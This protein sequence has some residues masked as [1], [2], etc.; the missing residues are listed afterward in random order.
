VSRH[1]GGRRGGFPGGMGGMGGGGGM[2]PQK[3]LQAAQA[4]QAEMQKAQE[5]LEKQL[6]EKTADGAAG[7][8]MVTV[9]ATAGMEIR[10]IKI[11]PSVI[12]AA[13]DTSGKEM[14]EDLV[15]AA[16]TAAL[17][18]AKNLR[19]EAQAE[20]QQKQMQQML[21]G[22]GLGGMGGLGDLGKLLGM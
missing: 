12:P 1:G 9:V 11:D 5:G 10:S 13:G 2:D 20:F 19:E 21:G 14:L 4:Q 18:K 3:M 17:K 22:M 8:G 16:V 15:A 7:G 6:A